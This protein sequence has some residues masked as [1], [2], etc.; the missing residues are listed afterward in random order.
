MLL[1]MQCIKHTQATVMD[2]IRAQTGW[3]QI[4]LCG[5]HILLGSIAVFHLQACSSLRQA[6]IQTAFGGE[7][8]IRL[9]NRNPI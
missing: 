8:V 7:N 2:I 3:H 5:L 4:Y 1:Q 9:E 6:V